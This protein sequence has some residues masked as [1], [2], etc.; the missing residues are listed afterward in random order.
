MKKVHES[1]KIDAA[2]IKSTRH[3]PLDETSAPP[4]RRMEVMQWWS[5]SLVPGPPA[6]MIGVRDPGLQSIDEQ[7]LKVRPAGLRRNCFHLENAH[8]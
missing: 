4:L 3:P 8:N 2:G 6:H 1:R 7:R 5:P